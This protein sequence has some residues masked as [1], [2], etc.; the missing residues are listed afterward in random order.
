MDAAYEEGQ[1][2]QPLSIGDRSMVILYG[3]E[4]GNSEEI[5]HELG[6]MAERLHF[7]IVVDEMDSFKLT[8]LLRFSLAIFV[9]STTGQGDMPKNTTKFWRNLR[10]EKLNNTNCL[11]TLKFSIFGLGDSSYQKFNWAARKLRVRLLQL[12]ASKFFKA[13]EG[14]ERH[15]DGIDSIYLPWQQELRASLLADYPL[16]DS[17]TPIPD[18]IQLPPR[19][20]LRLATSM[21]SG[22][23]NEEGGIIN[24]LENH[25]EKSTTS[26]QGLPPP[27]LVSIPGTFLATLSENVRVTPQGHWQD[28]RKLFLEVRF[29]PN[30]APRY[31]AGS[32]VT[33]YPK[34]YPEDVQSL[35]ELMGWGDVADKPL[36]WGY[37]PE[38][39]ESD[40]A[41]DIR[42]KRL[43]LRENGTPTTLRDLLTHNLDIMSIP[44]RHFIKE[45]VFFTQDPRE[46]ERLKELT[47][48][49]NEQDL[50]DYTSRPRRTIIEMLRDF[51][52]VRI[53]FN[54]VLNL[55]PIIRGRDFSLCNGGASLEGKGGEY[56]L[57][58]E[59]LAALV[60]FQTIIRKPR[61]GLCSRYLKHLSPG[62]TLRVGIKPAEKFLSPENSQ[63][64]H[65]L[66]AI[67]TGT[68]IAPIHALIEDRARFSG[69]GPVLLFYGCRSKD[70]DFY[71][72]ND[73]ARYPNMRVVP[74]FSRDPFDPADVLPA[75]P[76]RLKA[77]GGLDLPEP[78]YDYDVNKNYVQH[79]IR[80][81]ANEVGELM[82]QHPIVC[83]CG[84]AGK[85][86][87]SVRAALCDAL[88]VSNVVGT[89]KEAERFMADPKNL[90]MWQEVW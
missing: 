33:V 4:T 40:H 16:P 90:S 28:V 12:G 59:I 37:E 14:D 11:G 54:W 32:C 57:H 74:A 3:S 5:A 78:A 41:S 61:E 86:P 81:H 45:L 56:T 29:P 67:A 8:D 35:I 6:K 72:S 75:E 20:T 25:L 63:H 76:N 52:C 69:A 49:G 58:V 9:T 85:M 39:A 66:I 80:K 47:L 83:I 62:T 48:A 15:N 51:P 43:Y 17:V 1:V 60:E 44:K 13:G 68:G 82:R 7:R 88:V 55:I 2:A 38:T 84:N 36:A 70:A 18:D 77:D 26:N 79:H 34:N 53:P 71:F 23:K 89:S 46:K 73:W 27:D 19:Y 21:R 24:V 65:P 50:Y 22:E 64:Q 87:V 30:L 42:P 31:A 10:R